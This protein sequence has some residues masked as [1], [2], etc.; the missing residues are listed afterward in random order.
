MQHGYLKFAVLIL[1]LCGSLGAAVAQTD[2]IATDD[3]LFQPIEDLINSTETDQQVDYTFMTDNLEALREKPL[4]INLATRE[5]LLQLPG[6]SELTIN[7][8]F[9][10]IRKY[11]PLLNVYELQAVEGL[12]LDIIRQ[13][14]PFIKVS[15]VGLK[16]INPDRRMVK[17]PDF[18]TLVS[19][20]NFELTQRWAFSEQMAKGY[21]PADTSFRETRDTD[22]NLTGIDTSLSTRYAGSKDR[23]YTRLRIQNSPYF[24]FAITGE[25]DPGESFAVDLP[26]KK[27]GYD[28]L[29]AHI[30]IQNYGWLKSL[31]VGD[32]T[33]QA[34]QGLALSRGLGFGKGADVISSLKMPEL[35][36]RPYASVN[37]N[38]YFRGT[39][40][41]F[42]LGALRMTTFYSRKNVDAT[43][44]AV[45]TLSNDLLEVSG[46][47]ISGLH[48]SPSEIGNRK[49]LTEQLVGGRITWQLPTF[50]LGLTHYEQNF[51]AS[52]TK[53]PN[54][55]N[56][57]DFRGDHNRMTSVDFDWT[58]RNFN[59]FGET[60]RSKSGG[61]GSTTG[62]MISLHPKVD[63]A[64]Q[65]RHYDRDF[66]TQYG[67][68]FAERP[69]TLQ[70]ETGF[71]MG[72]KVYPSTRWTINAFFDQYAF[73]WNRF[74]A[75][76]PSKG[77][78]FLAQVDFKP[79]RGT[80]LYLRFRWDEKEEDATNAESVT[81]L[82]Y[83]VPFHRTSLRL[84]MQTKIN[85]QLEVRN[86]M[87]FSWY[88]KGFAWDLEKDTHGFMVYQDVMYKPFYRL[89]LVG[90]F[91][92]FDAPDYDSR[93]YAY[94]NDIPGFFSIPPLYGV[95]TRSYLMVQ[96]RL[97][98]QMD[99]WVRYSQ[100]RYFD[101][102]TF[103]SSLE[104]VNGNLDSEWKL[105]LRW[106]W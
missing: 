70:N 61:I 30:A 87:E 95:G 32:Y 66:H 79:R 105:Q 42:A 56:I 84:H 21:T 43:A 38:V 4:D 59:L 28:F 51:S 104:T 80:W 12:R 101:T 10:H 74:G 34:G 13:M 76:F 58:F 72:F 71:Y 16:D 64:F 39:A 31:V 35:G 49:S 100:T 53:A 83:L 99:L 29:S 1:L 15:Q 18:R 82:E 81:R 9:D 14:L 41:T 103:G 19:D 7:L 47:Q 24:S 40:A 67:F 89:R 17:G 65:F 50:R 20:L 97:W 5:Q 45:D 73:S 25:K 11:G 27:Y 6:M 94:E 52:L 44:Q 88:Q 68:S 46:L 62:L 60:A 33:I 2:S 106:K 3:P 77:H 96:V 86:R 92:V 63:A 75:G 26:S 90:R 22:G 78:E 37:E 54:D 48:R 98:R 69:T 8:L 85:N 55:Y 91:A 23:I 36:I 57:Y 102:K 93:I